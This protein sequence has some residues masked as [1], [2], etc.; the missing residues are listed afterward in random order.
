LAKQVDEQGT[1]YALAD[2]N[3]VS[4][5]HML[6]ITKRHVADFF[7]TTPEEQRDALVLLARL[8]ERL[9]ASDPS[10]V[11]FNAGVNCGREAGQT[12]M[13]VHIHLIPRR[14]GD[15]PDVRGG[16]RGVIPQKTS[17]P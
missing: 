8:R 17:W 13:H 6:V 15:T 11:G 7:A 4:E 3:P 2:L 1:V 12:V 14:T 16:I 10:I 5:G 9:L